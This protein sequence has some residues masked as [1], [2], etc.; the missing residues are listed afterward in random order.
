PAPDHVRTRLTEREDERR[1]EQ[2]VDKA[3]VEI[4]DASI[5]GGLREEGQ[6]ELEREP[7]EH[8]EQDLHEQALVRPQLVVEKGESPRLLLLV[9]APGGRALIKVGRGFEEEIDAGRRLRE[10]R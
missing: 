10:R 5:D 2:N 7:D 9:L 8:A 6:D 3:D 1:A 4:A